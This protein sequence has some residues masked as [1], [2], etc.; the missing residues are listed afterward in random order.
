MDQEKKAVQDIN[1]LFSETS[2]E[3]VNV[4]PWDHKLHP[5]TKPRFVQML[6]P[7]YG[8]TMPAVLT[9]DKLAIDILSNCGCWFLFTDGRIDSREVDRFS[10]GI[11]RHGLHGTASDIVIF[12]FKNTK[13]S[14]C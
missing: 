5:F 9:E 14:D 1:G 6:K 11:C 2:Q 13:P 8:G 7:D 3:K 12:G 10:R 4:L